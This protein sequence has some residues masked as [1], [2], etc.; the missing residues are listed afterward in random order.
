[1]NTVSAP[2]TNHRKLIDIP[3]DVFRASQ[4]KVYRHGH[5]P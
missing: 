5:E 4:Y 2:Q 1:M 3:E